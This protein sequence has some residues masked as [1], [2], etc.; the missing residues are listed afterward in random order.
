MNTLTE[1]LTIATRYASTRY[2]STGY[3]LATVPVVA[4]LGLGGAFFTYTGAIVSHLT[5]GYDLGEVGLLAVMATLT[6]LSWALR[7][8]SRRM[9][10]VA[11]GA[12]TP[13]KER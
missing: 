10:H 5:T 12:D 4:E 9:H 3:W 2:R 11:A 7:P 8:P 6:V 13:R 1:P